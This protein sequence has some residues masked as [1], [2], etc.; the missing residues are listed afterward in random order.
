MHDYYDFMIQSRTLVGAVASVFGFIKVMKKPIVVS[1]DKAIFSKYN[2][3][4]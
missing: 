1:I 2:L 3:R 4:S